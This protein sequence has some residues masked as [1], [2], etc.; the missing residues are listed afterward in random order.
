MSWI[1]DI[2]K[3]SKSWAEMKRFLTI[4][5]ITVSG[6]VVISIF[7]GKKV[8]AIT[9]ENNTEEVTLDNTLNKFSVSQDSFSLC[10]VTIKE[11]IRTL[12]TEF[13]SFRIQE[14]KKMTDLTEELN[15]T[16]KNLEFAVEQM[17][18][19]SA[20]QIIKAFELGKDSRPIIRPYYQKGEGVAIPIEEA[21]LV[22]TMP[23]YSPLKIEANAY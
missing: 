3:L 6:A 14:D 8:A 22:Y 21:S 12:N 17:D 4:G 5:A 10:L 11:E 15:R 23:W 7:V 1:K 19:M 2:I 20:R 9:I 16:N 18:S 13:N